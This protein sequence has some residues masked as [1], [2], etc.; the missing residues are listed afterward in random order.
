MKEV[1]VIDKSIVIYRKCKS[2]FHFLWIVSGPRIKQKGMN[3]LVF[4]KW[5]DLACDTGSSM[6]EKQSH[7]VSHA[8]RC[9]L[10]KDFVLS[11]I[12]FPRDSAMSLC[13][14]GK[15]WHLLDLLSYWF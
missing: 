12:A 2:Q 3:C 14:Q 10:L 8:L 9:S 4:W 7:L 11:Q 1:I 5:L 15:S 6:G 13:S